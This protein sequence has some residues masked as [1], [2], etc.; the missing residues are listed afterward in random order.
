VQDLLFLSH[1]IPYPPD[2]GEKIRAWNVL[3]HLA[4]SY[5][6]HLGCFIDEPA[7]WQYLPRL[8]AV[9]ADVA[10]FGLDRRW[11][12]ARALLQA[13]PGMPLSV[14]Y[15]R[16]ARLAR[17]VE[18]RL[19]AG[20]DRAFVYCSAMAPYLMDARGVHRVLDMVDVDSEKWTEYA[21]QAAWPARLVWAREGR[22]LLAFERRA[23][24]AFEHTVFVSEA[25]CR[26]FRTLAPEFLSPEMEGRTGWF[27]MGVDL[28]YLSPALVLPGPF[29]ADGP[30]LAF[31]GN[32]NYWPNVD[33]AGWF[34]R[35]V[36]PG[37]RHA[38]PELRFW[39]VGANPTPDVL[40]LATLPGV[41]VTGRVPDV[42]PYLA[43][44]AAAV[45]P[46]RIARGVQTK[47]LE[48]MAMGC[49]VVASPQAFEGLRFTPGHD[50]LIANGAAETARCIAEILQ[51]RH[52]GLG[53]AGRAAVERGYAWTATLAGL[54][55]LMEDASMDAGI[56]R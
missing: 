11:G 37:L 18:G 17:W 38:W 52:P 21:K 50:L 34:A 33:A 32:M 25:E 15:F 35:E 1:R 42:R 41:Q 29:D 28:D 22:T 31:V 43:H 10:C 8:H 47:V 54:D 48:A 26:R 16:N 55:A 3:G 5:R 36:L 6:I 39:I 46:L 4:R 7:D 53:A 40:R 56:R 9:C 49:P 2:K 23:A 45:A 14:G 19:A 44:A 20:I 13:K 27:D 51:G 30:N 24:A 12:K